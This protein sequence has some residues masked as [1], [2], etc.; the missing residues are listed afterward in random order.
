MSHE[1]EQPPPITRALSN[2]REVTKRSWN[3]ISC[4]MSSSHPETR[5][6]CGWRSSL[7]LTGPAQESSR[8]RAVFNNTSTDPGAV[9]QAQPFFC[10][11]LS[12]SNLIQIFI[13]VLIMSALST[14]LIHLDEHIP[15]QIWL[16]CFSFMTALPVV[17]E[18]CQEAKYCHSETWTLPPFKM[19][20][21]P[22]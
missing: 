18:Y 6:S 10:L 5:I 13:C 4:H 16:A 3:K 9:R 15:A 7:L 2:S 22:N 1:E 14:S 21:Y 20:K 19:K 11:Q 8:S 12:D 17:E